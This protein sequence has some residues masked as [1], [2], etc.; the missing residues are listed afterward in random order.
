[1]IATVNPLGDR[2]S[3]SYNA[4]G[5]RVARTDANGHVATTVYDAVGTA[6]AEINALGRRTTAVFD[7]AGRRIGI[8]DAN[9]GR[10]TYTH[11][12]AGRIV[13]HLDALGRATTFA[14]D[15][16]GRQTS[17]LDARGIEATF[18][19]DAANRLTSRTSTNDPP[20]TFGY[21]AVGNRTEAID[22]TGRSTFTYD[23]LG[24]RLTA[25]DP[26]GNAITYTYDA[27]D[28]RATMTAPNGGIFTYA[29]GPRGQIAHL[30]NPQGDRTTFSYDA[31]S[32]RTLTELAN[33][34]RASY[35]YDGAS[36][37]AQL[38]NLKADDSVILGLT[39]E[40]DFAGNPIGM[41]ES[42]GDRVTWTYDAT[43]RL[44]REQRSGPSRYDTTYTYDPLGNRLVK[45]ASGVLTTYAYDLANELTTSQDTSGVTTYTYDLA[46]NLGVVQRPNGQR[47]TTTWND[48]NQQ[49]HVVQP[50]GAITTS[51]YCFNGLRCAKEDSQG[52]LKYIWDF[53]NYL[54]EAHADN[55][56]Q[57]VYTN[58][59]QTYGNLISQW[60]KTPTIWIP[61]YHHFDALGSTRVLTDASAATTDTFVCDSWGNEV[62]VS[63]STVNPF[64]WVGQV[65]YYYDSG[66]MTYYVRA[67]VYDPVTGRWTSQDPLFFP[68]FKVTGFLNSQPISREGESN[69]YGYIRSRPIQLVDPS[70][71]LEACC[72]G[73]CGGLA[74]FRPTLNAHINGLINAAIAAAAT[75]G[76]NA[77][78]V[79]WG[80]TALDAAVWADTGYGLAIPTTAIENWIHTQV[81]R[82]AVKAGLKKQFGPIRGRLTDTA[83]CMNIVCN[84]RA[85][86]VGSDKIGHFFQQGHMG[87]EIAKKKGGKYATAF[88]HWTEGIYNIIES[89]AFSDQLRWLQ[90]EKFEFH[91]FGV[92]DLETYQEEWGGNVAPG[93]HVARSQADVWAN[94][95]GMKFWEAFDNGVFGPGK[96]T[97]DICDYLNKL[98]SWI[99]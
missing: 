42:G 78:S 44:T 37:V 79:L 51:T 88:F 54:G 70:G 18:Q 47:T 5:L 48:Q 52:M 43:D 68:M 56:I 38:Y 53:Q 39:Y 75:P 7:A 10:N 71:W 26:A 50:N 8:L 30:V 58:E 27:L 99:E 57:V 12:A 84:G 13:Q 35:T 72:E 46:G 63:G 19:Y 25:V 60:R 81:G 89:Q 16:A 40:R 83:D 22:A 23:L 64:Q 32:R 17:I 59:P 82:G 14:Y 3:F 93:T 74:N 15:A 91:H 2:T 95:H 67:R 21:D 41:L 29:Y 36:R 45:E 86:C 85:S 31:A 4:A 61:R 96:K 94:Y 11:D 80:W 9:G 55:A 77:R 6:I 90:T 92:V 20:V 62:A 69:L 34:T 1:L 97:F 49:T 65:G 98:G 28:Q 76:T 33:G 73:R 66:L 24:R 87:F